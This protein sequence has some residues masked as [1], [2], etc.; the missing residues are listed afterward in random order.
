MFVKLK[1]ENH[2]SVIFSYF[3]HL[4]SLIGMKH[5]KNNPKSSIKNTNFA[6]NPQGPKKE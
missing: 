2:K 5:Y 1:F 6:I 4:W 3:Y